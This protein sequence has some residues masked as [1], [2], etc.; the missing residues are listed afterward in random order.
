MK[1]SIQSQNETF[2]V[3]PL[4]LYLLK[5][6]HACKD[7]E[8]CN[9]NPRRRLSCILCAP[10]KE[11]RKMTQEKPESSDSSQVCYNEVEVDIGLSGVRAHTSIR[12]DR[13]LWK[14]FKT[15][16]KKN[17]LSTCGILEKLILGFVVGYSTS[18][19]QPTT[20][21]VIV[22]APRIIK[23][24]RRRQLV[25]EDEITVCGFRG[26]GEPAVGSGVWRGSKEFLLCE[27]HLEE[28]KSQ[29]REWNITKET[30]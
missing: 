16:C 10:R 12:C 1:D 19:A 3:S 14:S 5:F 29:R 28:A 25:I 17:G 6:C 30:L 18:V 26:C 15:V 23:R 13:K 4:H 8:Y 7:N 9:V 20:I 22:D 2:Y 27:K 24:V 11:P 21:N